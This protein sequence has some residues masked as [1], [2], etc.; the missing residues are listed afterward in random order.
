MQVLADQ[1]PTV[2]EKAVASEQH[3]EGW[4]AVVPLQPYMQLLGCNF[5]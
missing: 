5:A 4:A 1:L 3:S 2:V